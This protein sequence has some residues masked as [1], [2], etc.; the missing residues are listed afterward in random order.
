[1]GRAIGRRTVE[2]A[3]K[4]VRT[5]VSLP[6]EDYAEIER[7]AAA[8]DTS[9]AWVVRAAVRDYLNARSPLFAEERA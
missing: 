3:K 8:N 9:A 7:I 1:M 6:A 4:T 5:T 2:S